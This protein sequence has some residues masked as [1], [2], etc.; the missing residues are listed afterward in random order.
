MRKADDEGFL[1]YPCEPDP[2]RPE[3]YGGVDLV[4]QHCM[5][6]EI[7]EAQSFR[8]LRD[9][10]WELNHAN[11]IFRTYGCDFGSGKEDDGTPYAGLML[12]FGFRHPE[13]A[14][15]ENTEQLFQIFLDQV[16]ER[17]PNSR[18]WL[19]KCLDWFLNPVFLYR[20]DYLSAVM[21]N[22]TIHAASEE[23]C[24]NG[25]AQFIADL[26]QYLEASRRNIERESEEQ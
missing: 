19:E 24:L 5:V 11:N 22:V 8:P 1:I 12:H 23:A 9:L 6:D 13:H 26:L 10:L 16:L 3:N 25:L 17:Y 15:S 18:D 2:D 21:F 7:K 4:A 14:T 20:Q